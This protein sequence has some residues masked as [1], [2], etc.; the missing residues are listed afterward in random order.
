Y[1]RKN[2][3]LVK[4]ALIIYPPR[5][6]SPSTSSTPS[7]CGSSPFLCTLCFRDS[8]SEPD[9]QPSTLS[10]SHSYRHIAPAPLPLAHALELHWHLHRNLLLHL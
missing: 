8:S 3:I 6:Y 4:D 9:S 7:P 10:L 5:G 2:S 1:F